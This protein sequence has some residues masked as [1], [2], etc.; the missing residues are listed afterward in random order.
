MIS[1]LFLLT[2]CYLCYILLFNMKII[3][4]DEST[5]TMGDI[6]FSPLR[7]LG[8]YTGYPN[9]GEDET[10]GRAALAEIVIAN[11]APLTR[12]VIQNLKKLR[13]IA[14]I[15]TG[16]NNVDLESAKTE[17]VKVCNVP[18]Y[19]ANSV[20]QHVFALILNLAT[21]AYLYDRDVKSGKWRNAAFFT[22]LT[23]PTFELSGKTIGIIGFGTIGR[24]VAGIAETFEMKVLAF[25]AHGIKDNTYP[26]TALDT[27]FRESDII[28]VHCPLTEET[29]NL[30]NAAAFAGMKK[31]AFLINTARGGIVD[32]NALADALN[33]GKIAGAGVDVLTE[34]PPKKGNV[35]IDAKNIIITPHSAWSTVEARQKLVDETALNI[36]AFI[37][38][39]QRNIVV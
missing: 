33:T 22:L 38:G 16:Y 13:L 31:T 11:K 30:I 23:Y 6:D 25:S 15:A 34:E 19:A 18:G 10:V 35:L 24:A 36:R 12:R 5:I 14:V 21:R 27:I 39:Q 4:L 26:N 3:F 28:S 9:S 20:P 37:D 17:R 2:F 8:E 7:T 29:R 32:E 1:W